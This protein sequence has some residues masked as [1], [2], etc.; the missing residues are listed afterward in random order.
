M[1]VQATYW[2]EEKGADDPAK[3]GICSNFLCDA[4][5]GDEV[6]MTGALLDPHW[7]NSSCAP[8]A[9]AS[10]F[11]A[12]PYNCIIRSSRGADSG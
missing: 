9:F 8:P 3:K 10:P 1:G 11:C 6:T 5:P 4:K 7:P 12:L 2:D